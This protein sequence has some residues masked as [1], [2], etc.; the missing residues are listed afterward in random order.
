MAKRFD[1]FVRK[2]VFAAIP[3][4]VRPNHLSIARGLLLAPLLVFSKERAVAIGIVL[5]SSLCDLLDGPLARLRGIVSKAGAVIDAFSDK[6]FLNG[7]LFFA[8]SHAIPA[9]IRWTALV[10]DISLMFV[11]PVKD[12]LGLSV[13]ANRWG[14]A[15]AWAQTFGICFVLTQATDLVLLGAPVYLLAILFAVLD[16]GGHIRDIIAAPRS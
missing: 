5:L 1:R 4:W 10:L 14:G 11:R 9:W 7:A 16:V 13:N 12:R 8:C 6:V 2:T 3:E 15:K